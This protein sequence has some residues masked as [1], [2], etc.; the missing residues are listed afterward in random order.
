MNISLNPP[1]S[2]AL[3]GANISAAASIK[4][5]VPARNGTLSSPRAP[6]RPTTR[7]TAKATTRTTPSTA[8]RQVFDAAHV[9]AVE[10]E[11]A[12]IVESPLAPAA[13]GVLPADDTSFVG[14]VY[15][16]A[17]LELKV[18][19]ATELFG[20]NE[21]RSRS[22][23][24]RRPVPGNV[25]SAACKAL[26]YRIEALPATSV[27]ICFHN[28]AWSTLMRTVWSVIDRTPPSLLAEVIL[29]DDGSTYSWLQ[30]SLRSEV[31]SNWGTRVRLMRLPQRRGILHARLAGAHASRGTVLTFLDSHCEVN[32]RWYEPLAHALFE[33]ENAIIIPAVEA[34]DPQTLEYSTSVASRPLLGSF[35]WRFDFVWKH[36]AAIKNVTD[37]P[38]SPVIPGG[39]FSMER[40]WFLKIG[41][42][43]EL[44]TGMSVENLDLS[45]RA[46]M[47][48]GGVFM[49]P[50]SHMGHIYKP[51]QSFTDAVEADK[52]WLIDAARVAEVWLDEYKQYFYA[53][54][55][56]ANELA[57]GDLKS[58]LNVK[59]NLK[60]RSFKWY[61]IN[62]A[63]DV[64]VPDKRRLQHRGMLQGNKGRCLDKMGRNAG[65]EPGLYICHGKNAN[66]YRMHSNINEIRTIDGF[67]LDF[68]GRLGDSAVMQTCHSARGN[69]EWDYNE[70]KHLV[71]V[72]SQL[73]LELTSEEEL[74]LMPCEDAPSQVWNWVPIKGQ[75]RQPK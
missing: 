34:I 73:C 48:A 25:I 27:I 39:V 63:K 14:P 59:K 50:C 58:M 22:I 11:S 30:D 40:T 53:A 66:Q 74:G 67:C 15:R 49:A 24:T 46:W 7:T 6:P 60:C 16:G 26:K 4:K 41:R 31:M 69:Q 12:T 32:V 43:D 10:A 38:R 35:S 52:N 2:E 19:E 42:Y 72:P 37:L 55:V 28:E 61:L 47:C 1:S 65:G 71:H 21:L 45:F 64:F 62:V 56:T 70:V 20:F 33:H 23:S 51:R 17:T 68:A 3:R 57:L 54:R 75:S 29:V 8:V 18:K 13:A 9:I 5:P 44:M 36:G